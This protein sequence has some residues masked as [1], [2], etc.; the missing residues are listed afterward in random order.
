MIRAAL[1]ALI[2]LCGTAQA[3][4]PISQW[5]IPSTG[6]V[7]ISIGDKGVFTRGGVSYALTAGWGGTCGANQWV[8][9]INSQGV[10]IC[11]QPAFSNI[12]GYISASQL[13][14]SYTLGGLDVTGNV[15]IGTATPA[16]ALD[17]WG[18]YSSSGTAGVSCSGSPTSSFASIHGIVTHC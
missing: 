6:S 12:S 5:A 15:G 10:P 13:S 11:S 3:Q 7:N 8:N 4:V 17:V 9:I 16:S 14:G 18:T 1:L 2:L